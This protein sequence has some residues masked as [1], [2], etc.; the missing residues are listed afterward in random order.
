LKRNIYLNKLTLKEAQEKFY[1]ALLKYKLTQPLKGESVST[2]DSLGR[3]TAEPIFARIILSLLSG[4]S[5]G[6]G[7]S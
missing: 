7:S 4:G 5:N 2:E 6:R 3:I 1:R